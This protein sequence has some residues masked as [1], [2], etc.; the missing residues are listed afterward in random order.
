MKASSIELDQMMKNV[1]RE[2]IDDSSGQQTPWRL[3]ST[4]GDFYFKGGSM[5]SGDVPELAGG[6]FQTESG[7]KGGIA[8]TSNPPGAQIYVNGV[9]EG[10]SPLTMNFL[11]GIYTVEARKEGY[12]S[13]KETVRV[14]QGK[15][16]SLNL[17][18]D[19]AGGSIWIKS[20][21]DHAK[22]YLN[23][24]FY[25][26]TPDTIKGLPSGSYQVTLKKDGYED[27]QQSHQVAPGRELTLNPDLKAIAKTLPVY[28]DPTTGME[29]ALIK[30]D[31]FEM[32]DSFNEGDADEKPL[33]R[34]CLDDFYLGTHEVTVGQF[35][36]F[37]KA[38]GYKTEA[39]SGGGCFIWNGGKW[40][41]KKGTSF[42]NPGFSQDENHA[43]AC[44][45]WNDSRKFIEWLNGNSEGKY[46]LPTEAEWEYACR[47]GGR[48]VRYG[49]GTDGITT[50][51]ANYSN[52]LGKTTAVGSYK[53]N[54]L[55]LYD[56]SGNVWEW[57]AD[58][59]DE[60]YYKNSPQDN[61]KG[62]STGSSRVP[63]G[64]SWITSPGGLR[65]S[66]RFGITPVSRPYAL[67]LRLARTP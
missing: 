54:T 32:G 26:E 46:R 35:M 9:L 6:S 51:Q 47:E 10:T 12:Q 50:N 4:T 18:L 3:S 34:V 60:Y 24:V 48:N 44:V 22:I 17:L 49:T 7:G 58:W 53:T 27:W 21:P 23:N 2:V 11:A 29:F 64:G 56:M 63:R 43:V 20:N 57:T 14:Q 13:Q 25:G 55:G 61:P 66:Y 28:T 39:E 62:P 45:S 8:V 42:Q 5:P 37:T 31:C 59:Y 15:Q 30:G 38:T 52:T 19:K 40:E 67:G 33:H 1:T 41:T 36:E 16:L 65:C